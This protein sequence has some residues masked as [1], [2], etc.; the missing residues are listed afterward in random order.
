MYYKSFIARDK[1]NFLEMEIQY[2]PNY[3]NTY[4]GTAYRYTAGWFYGESLGKNKTADRP[5][6]LDD[7]FITIHKCDENFKRIEP[8]VSKGGGSWLS[9]LEIDEDFLRSILYITK[10]SWSNAT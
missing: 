6:R 1:K 8:P 9:H 3:A 2:N 4:T 7:I 5:A 10:R